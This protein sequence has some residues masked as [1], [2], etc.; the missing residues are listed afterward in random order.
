VHV[1]LPASIDQTLLLVHKRFGGVAGL[2]VAA[3]V[4]EFTA[5]MV[6]WFVAASDAYTP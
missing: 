1:S 4:H 2:D 3:L 5:A 6:R